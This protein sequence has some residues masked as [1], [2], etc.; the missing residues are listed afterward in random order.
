M[1]KNSYRTIFQ[2]GR[3]E[4]IIK[5]SRFIGYAMPCETEKEAIEFIRQINEI[6]K[7]A[8]HNCYA[9]CI[10][11]NF[12]IQRYSDDGE[13]Q[14]TAGVPIL[15]VMKKENITNA[16]I[17]VTRYFGGIKLGAS[18][19]IRAYTEGAKIALDQSKPV[20]KRPFRRVKVRVDYPLIGR[21]DY[22]IIQAQYFELNREYL[23]DVRIEFYIR[24]D[25]LE[26][27]RENFM[28]WTGGTV[29]MEEYEQ[30]WLA[31]VD[32]KILFDQDADRKIRE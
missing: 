2:F 28:E 6:H 17:V 26:A 29:Q 15:E 22:E 20:I 31:S 19:L 7:Q 4:I 21:I 18:G 9:Y 1:N 32:R 16:A 24:E 10:G 8:T 13:P 5:K 12:G 27:F 30:E 11:Q 25:E 23:E 3:D 14:G